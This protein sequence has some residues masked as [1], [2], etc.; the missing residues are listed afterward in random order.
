M[1]QLSL[2]CFIAFTLTLNYFSNA[3]KSSINLKSSNRLNTKEF[4]GS[5]ENCQVAKMDTYEIKAKCPKKGSDELES[6]WIDLNYCFKNDDG[7]LVHNPLDTRGANEFDDNCEHFYT[8]V[9]T[10]KYYKKKDNGKSSTREEDKKNPY[11]ING[12]CSK[13]N[14]K[15]GWSYLNVYDYVYYKEDGNMSCE[16]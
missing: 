15:Q 12:Y 4:R 2:F 6:S 10:V 3:L 14:G 8:L 5:L 1:K 11:Y 13:N 9:S 16:K 7:T